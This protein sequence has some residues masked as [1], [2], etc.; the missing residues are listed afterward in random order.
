V[1]QQNKEDCITVLHK[2]EELQNM[3]RAFREKGPNQ[4]FRMVVMLETDLEREASPDGNCAFIM[5]GGAMGLGSMIYDFLSNPGAERIVK[6]M[7]VEQLSEIAKRG[8]SIEPINEVP[9]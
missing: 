3:V 1:D 5:Y 4:H 8:R 9:V 6:A 2:V 7:I